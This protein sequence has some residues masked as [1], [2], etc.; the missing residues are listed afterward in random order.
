MELNRKLSQQSWQEVKHLVLD[1]CLGCCL[2]CM[3]L[4]F[5][6]FHERGEF[7]SIFT[8]SLT[9]ETSVICNNRGYGD[10]KNLLRPNS[11]GAEHT[12]TFYWSAEEIL[13]HRREKIFPLRSRKISSALNLCA[14]E[15]CLSVCRSN[16]YMW[17]LRQPTG[18]RQLSELL[19]MHYCPIHPHHNI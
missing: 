5:Y 10:V 3:V 9:S 2:I 18:I 8:S 7:T 15:R 4:S 16:L 14:A 17:L 19:Y 12:Y 11:R 13:L 1:D 6:N